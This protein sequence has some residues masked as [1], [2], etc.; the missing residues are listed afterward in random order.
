MT[1]DK[2]Y[3]RENQTKREKQLW[4]FLQERK[5]GNEI[6]Q[7]TRKNSNTEGSEIDSNE[8]EETTKVRSNVGSDKTGHV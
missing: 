3:Q 7:P 2:K 1:K 8:K 5:L 4:Q 6:P